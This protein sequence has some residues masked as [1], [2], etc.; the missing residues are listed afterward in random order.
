M[1]HFEVFWVLT[2]CSIVVIRYQKFRG[3]CCLH[4]HPEVGGSMELRNVGILAQH[5]RGH[6]PE[7]MD[8]A[9]NLRIKRR[10]EIQDAA[11][12][13]ATIKPTIINLNTV[14]LNRVF[15][16]IIVAFIIARFSASPCMG[17]HF[18]GDWL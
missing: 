1:F 3:P 14:F 7:D 5:Y 13:M 12:K 4:L 11:E 9:Y 17:W 6:N 10:H 8:L 2:P 16:L 18:S 15:E